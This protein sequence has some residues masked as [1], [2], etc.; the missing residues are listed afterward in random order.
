MPVEDAAADGGVHGSTVH[1]YIRRG[2]LR[3]WHRPGD[4]RT[5]VDIED[6]RGLRELGPANPEQ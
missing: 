5:F 2:L 3:R 1:R 6:L 4:A